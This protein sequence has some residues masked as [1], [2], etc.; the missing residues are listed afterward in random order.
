MNSAPCCKRQQPARDRL[1]MEFVQVVFFHQTGQRAVMCVEAIRHVT[2]VLPLRPSLFHKS[3]SPQTAT[4]KSTSPQSACFG[5]GYEPSPAPSTGQSSASRSSSRLWSGQE[6]SEQ[7]V[8]CNRFCSRWLL[9]LAHAF[10]WALQNLRADS[11]AC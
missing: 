10:Y 1:Y 4:T 8:S 9:N 2:C 11:R 6:G 3:T 7:L 5:S